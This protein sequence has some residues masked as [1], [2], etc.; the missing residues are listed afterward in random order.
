MLFGVALTSLGWVPAPRR[1][2]LVLAGATSGVLGTA[3]S[4]GGPPMALVWQR[5][6]GS[7]LAR[8]DERVLP[9]RV[10]AVDR[11]AGRSPARSHADTFRTFAAAD[12]RG[13]SRG[14]VLSRYVNGLLNPQRQRWTAIAM[15]AAGAAVL[16]AH[17][18][19]S[20]L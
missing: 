11:R 1:R 18:V 19:G 15:S 12:A 17:E 4:I 10:G 16:I 9:R 13:R 14:Y 5:S 6:S 8:H 20:C 3:T 7:E 2:N